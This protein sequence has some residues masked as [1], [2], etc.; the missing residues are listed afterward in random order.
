MDAIFEHFNISFKAAIAEF[1]KNELETGARDFRRMEA[2]W[3]AE[4]QKLILENTQMRTM[5][6]AL[7][8]KLQLLSAKYHKLCEHM[9]LGKQ[10]LNTISND[11][12]GNN[13]VSRKTPNTLVSCS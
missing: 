3:C 4:Q 5:I 9:M 12:D 11:F 1:I 10:L 13:V 8:G 2:Q 7:T 6:A